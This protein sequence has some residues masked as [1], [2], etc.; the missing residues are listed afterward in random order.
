MYG[1]KSDK[2]LRHQIE[3]ITAARYDR[4]ETVQYH[5]PYGGLVGLP[6]CEADSSYGSLRIRGL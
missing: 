1:S 2:V 5:E 3:C 4:E 6:S